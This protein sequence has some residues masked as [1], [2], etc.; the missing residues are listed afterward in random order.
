MDISD[1]LNRPA[2]HQ[3]A[4]RLK[5]VIWVLTIIVLGVVGA[6][7]QIKFP[8]PEGMSLGFLP[9]VHAT[10]NSL[11]AILLVA[12]FVFIKRKQVNAHKT[13]INVAMALSITFL[14]CYVA[15]HVTTPETKFGG[16]GAIKYIYYVLLITHIALAALSFPFILF[17]WM[18]GVTNQFDKHRRMAKLVFPIWLY[19]AITGP[20]CYLLLR[21]YY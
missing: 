11:V 20:V 7:R 5:I 19:V 17:T 9:A 12:A 15:Y 16:T 18:Y 14:C 4:S 6:M 2:N 1:Y 10:L 8:L 21:P 3:L 13:A